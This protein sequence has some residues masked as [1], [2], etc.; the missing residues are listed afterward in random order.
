MNKKENL[1]NSHSTIMNKMKIL[2]LNTKYLQ[3][4]QKRLKNKWEIKEMSAPI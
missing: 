2:E 4:I 3:N 1:T